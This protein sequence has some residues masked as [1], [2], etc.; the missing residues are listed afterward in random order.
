MS[1]LIPNRDEVH[2]ILFFLDLSVTFEGVC[3]FWVSSANQINR[4]DI[5]GL[6]NHDQTK[7]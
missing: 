7:L 5:T 2:L 4:H 3:S 1:I 6:G